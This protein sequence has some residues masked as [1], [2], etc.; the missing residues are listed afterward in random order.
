MREVRAPCRLTNNCSAE[1][2]ELPNVK[3]EHNL[4]GGGVK[5]EYMCDTGPGGGCAHCVRVPAPAHA[6]SVRAVTRGQR[7]RVRGRAQARVQKP[8]CAVIPEP[9]DAS[10]RARLTQMGT[11]CRSAA[12]RTLT[13]PI[14]APN[15]GSR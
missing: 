13:S 6:P 4:H 3:R 9:C 5:T 15:V 11:L 12:V 7:D 2:V 1:S 10:V 8:A 14:R